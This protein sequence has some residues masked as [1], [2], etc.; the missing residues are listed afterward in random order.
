MARRVRVIF[1][2]PTVAEWLNH[3]PAASDCKA[4]LWTSL[5]SVASRKPLEYYAFRKVLRDAAVRAKIRKRANPHAFR[6]ARAS[7][8]A[9]DLTEAQMKELFGWT[10][11]SKMAGVYVRLSGRNIDN[12]LLR[13]SG[14]KTE[15]EV[16]E[17]EHTLQVKVCLRCE[18][19]NSPTSRF[20][21]RC[22]LPLDLKTA[23]DLR[24]EEQRTDDL[25][26]RLLEDSEVKQL[27]MMKLR[28]LSV[29]T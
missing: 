29:L 12:A 23:M 25:M 15:E 24:A 5:G 9:A 6:H 2:S 22:G 16:R 4:P 3:H 20:C 26:S 14:I 18:E 7:N 27:L 17:E 13:L 28:E 10:Q 1:S 19:N 11:D 8:L 21:T